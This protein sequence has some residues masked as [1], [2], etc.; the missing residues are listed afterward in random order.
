MQ[1]LAVHPAIWR[2]SLDVL[3]ACFQS[4]LCAMGIP[5]GDAASLLWDFGTAVR[6]LT[7]VVHYQ[8]WE[9]LRASPKV[10]ELSPV[11]LCGARVSHWLCR[12]HRCTFQG[13]LT[14]RSW[15]YPG[16]SAQLLSVW[17]CQWPAC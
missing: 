8:G 3:C 15:K 2:H 12:S 5:V 9:A 1:V 7:T 17:C 14:A 4:C 10:K 11:S 16:T 6:L 13:V